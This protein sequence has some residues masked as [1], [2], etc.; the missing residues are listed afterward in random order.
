MSFSKELAYRFSRL[1]ISEKLIIINVAVF[2]I[3]SLSVFLFK[4]NPNF[5]M[6]WFELPRDIPN[7]ITQPW[8]LITYS[9]FHG[10]FSHLFWNMLLL[11]FSGR[12]FLNLFSPK[13]LLSIY[14]LGAAFG[15]LLFLLSYNLFPVFS[16]IQTAL[17]GASAAVMAVL[18]FICSYT[19][20]SVVVRLIFFN[21]KLWYIGAFFVIWDL[22]QLP[23]GNSGG[24]LAHLGGAFI[25]F[26][27]ARRLREGKDPGRWLEQMMSGFG[28]T[29]KKKKS[30]L[31]T[32]YKNQRKTTSKAASGPKRNG[33][34]YQRKIDTILDKISKSGYESL[35]KEEKD[36]LFKAGEQ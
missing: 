22:I 20:N 10:G 27:Y 11:Y 2:I 19:P 28:G 6:R 36:F 1:Y 26:Y 5:F 32:V 33:D 8:S 23:M 34:E 18:I 24:H 13:R 7:F 3:N 17:I 25:G 35:S 31:K 29:S 14:I 4:L 16:G 21:V 9:F 12:L 15:G 30:P